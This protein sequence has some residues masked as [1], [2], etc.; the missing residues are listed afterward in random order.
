MSFRWKIVF[1]LSAFLLAA[2]STWAQRAPLGP[3]DPHIG[4]VYPAGGQQGTT[5]EITVGGQFLDGA[6]DVLVSGKGVE[7]TVTKH[8]KPL[9]QKQ[10]NDLR[11]KV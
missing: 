7:A 6:S 10:I 4:Y 3:R 11:Q 8:T 9:T 1:C 5:L 2:P